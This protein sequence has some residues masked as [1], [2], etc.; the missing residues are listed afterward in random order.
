[1]CEKL[2]RGKEK[3]L[4]VKLYWWEDGAGKRGLVQ[5]RGKSK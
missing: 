4:V 3:K 1:M 2:E 5:Y